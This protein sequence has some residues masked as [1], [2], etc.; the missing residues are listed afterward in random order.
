MKRFYAIAFVPF[1]VVA[2]GA[3]TTSSA[4]ATTFLLAEWLLNGAA[5]TTEKLVELP[6]ELRLGDNEIPVIGKATIL[7]SF[8]FNGWVGPNSLDYI[9]EILNDLNE[10]ISNTQLVNLAL[11]CSP[12]TGCESGVNP[13]VWPIGMPWESSAELMEQENKNY[14][15]D[16]LTRSDGGAIGW[17]IAKCLVLGVEEGDECTATELVAELWLISPVQQIGFSSAFTKLAGAKALKCTQ[18][19]KES[20]EMEGSDAFET[21]EGGEL[22]ASSES[23]IA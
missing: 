3:I 2:L 19:G 18:S 21:A 6:G 8:R 9:S 23:V 13:E 1:V 7:C 4:F 5:L 12:Q 22:V 11:V 16:L 15:A 14:F 10:P 20:G 17:E